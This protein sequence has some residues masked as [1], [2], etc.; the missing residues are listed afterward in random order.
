MILI[1]NEASIIMTVGITEKMIISDEIVMI[2]I[3][4][5]HIKMV[6]DSKV[7]RPGSR[8][9]ITM[10]M[11]DQTPEVIYGEMA[12]SIILTK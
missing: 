4:N 9:I 12:M 7:T 5:C 3:W 6:V 2:M 8:E 1:D 10:N 11:T